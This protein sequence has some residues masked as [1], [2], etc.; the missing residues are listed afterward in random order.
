MG[1]GV[2]HKS[3]SV[4]VGDQDSNLTYEN[5]ASKVSGYYHELRIIDSTGLLL[6]ALVNAG[7]AQAAR[8]EA[9]EKAK[10]QTPNQDGTV[11]VEVHYDPMPILS[12][13]LTDL[14]F[15]FGLGDTELS[16]PEGS[17]ATGGLTWWEADLRPE[18]YTF[19]PIK[20]LP[21][22]SS[23]FL[24]MLAG[25]ITSPDGNVDREL[26]L[27]S[28]D[29]TAG[30]STTYIVTPNLV[31]TGRISVGFISPLIGALVG[32]NVFHPSAELEVGWR[33]FSTEKIG[34]MIGG[35]AEIARE[36]ALTRSMTTTR[37]GLGVTITFGMQTPKAARKTTTTPDPAPANTALSGNICLGDAAPADCKVVDTLPDA[38]KVLYLACAQATVNAAN[39]SDFSQQ[40]QVCRKAGAGITNFLASNSAT[41]DA[42]TRRNLHIAAATMFDFA[43]AGYEV[44]SGK[45]TADHCAAIEGVYNHVIG[46]DGA[47]PVLPTK[48]KISDAAVSQCRAQYTCQASQEDGMTCTSK[49]APAP[50]APVEPAPAPTPAA[51]TTPAP[52]TP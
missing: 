13:L 52:A 35:T 14:R 16:L 29:L 44:T 51:P 7:K 36:W 50:A 20:R 1:Y 25:Q 22:V 40:P 11:T 26:D 8:D 24:G 37:V 42:A 19:R 12:G 47:N 18:F 17:M 10:Y 43:G 31:A 32:G 3:R 48:V 21:M 45:L 33:P 2:G 9:I 28:L 23:L 5:S 4:G 30:A 34:V 38:P 49:T 15:R 39:T 41:L 27:F 6:A 46:D